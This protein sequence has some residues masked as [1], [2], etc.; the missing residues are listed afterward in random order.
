VPD[1][2]IIIFLVRFFRTDRKIGSYVF[3]PNKGDLLLRQEPRPRR[4][5][6]PLPS[7]PPSCGPD[8]SEPI[9]SAPASAANSYLPP[10]SSRLLSLLSGFCYGVGPSNIYAAFR[11]SVPN[12][13]AKKKLASSLSLPPP[14]R[15]LPQRTAA[16][17][18]AARPNPRSCLLLLSL[19]L[20][21]P[22]HWLPSN[23]AAS[24]PCAQPG[25]RRPWFA[26]RPSGRPPAVAAFCHASVRESP[27]A[28]CGR[29]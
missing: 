11:F 19:S 6:F 18:A 23:A 24:T 4:P 2:K 16:A 13:P 8:R 9:L 7:D 21:V 1:R 15:L 10:A 17:H 5:N 14:P 22:A 28:G 27:A 3:K 20:D 29:R 26:A 25:R 12:P